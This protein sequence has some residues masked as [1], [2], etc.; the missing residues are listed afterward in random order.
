MT[1]HVLFVQGGGKGVHDEWDNK[2]VDSLERELGPDFTVR[3]PRMPHEG[4]PTY[5]DWKAA[6]KREFTRLEEGALL[7]GHSI[8]A[9]I[10]IRTIADDPPKQTVGGIFLIAA[11][12]VGEGGWTTEDIEPLSDLGARLPDQTP[13]YLYHGSEDETAPFAHVDLY[14]KAIPQ[15]IVRRLSGRDHQLNND[16]ADVA[17]DVR[18]VRAA[19]RLPR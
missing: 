7:I 1:I 17:A 10:L 5:A 8:G 13:I 3:Y 6:L 14:A 16:M 19:R 2:I 12:F 15:A 18:R 9:T 4:D 11:P